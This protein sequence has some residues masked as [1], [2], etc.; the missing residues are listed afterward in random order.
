MYLMVIVVWVVKWHGWDRPNISTQ[1]LQCIY[2]LLMM[3][4][5]V[6]V[7]VYVCVCVWVCVVIGDQ[8]HN[9][10]FQNYSY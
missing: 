10:G 1:H 5:C 2:L 7:C 3:C 4:V 8:H 9:S 6:C